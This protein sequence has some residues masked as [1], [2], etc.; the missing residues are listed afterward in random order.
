VID[1]SLVTTLLVLCLLVWLP[2]LLIQ[3]EQRG[4]LVFRIWLLTAP[5][6]TNI[7]AYPTL[8]PFFGAPR[9]ARGIQVA[10]SVDL[11][12]HGTIHLVEIFEPSRLL[13]HAFI[14]VFL[15]R[16]AVNRRVSVHWDRTE[17][18]MGVFSA[19]S[20]V[21]VLLKSEW[22][23]YGLRVTSDAFVVPFMGYFLARRFVTSEEN[24]R[25][26][27]RVIG[28][29]GFYLI[30]IALIEQITREQTGNFYRL[31]GP[32]ANRDLLYIVI[33]VSFFSTLLGS[34]G[35]K[36]HPNQSRALAPGVRMFVLAL[37]P[38]IIFLSWTR[39][40]WLGFISATGI[41]LVLGHRFITPG[42]KIGGIGIIL[43]LLPVVLL[44]GTESSSVDTLEERA[45]YTDTGY[46]RLAAWQV[47]IQEGMTNPLFGIG[48]NNLRNVLTTSRI[49]M[50][51]VR[52]LTV[53]HNCFLG[54]FVEL[55]AVGL[56]LY[57]LIV[58]CIIHTGLIICR[59]G[60][61]YRDRWRGI[62]VV[63]ILAAYLIPAFFSTILYYPGVSHIYVFAYAGAIVGLYRA[64]HSAEDIKRALPSYRTRVW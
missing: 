1:I 19:F 15:L 13:F 63:A 46:A 58:S 30:V 59:L 37:A 62:A 17:T 48:L 2:L 8:N 50:E 64:R 22:P 14:I 3:I 41:V 5:I 31:R 47:A 45:L 28:H 52:S 42:L 7:V 39:G 20:F 56:L 21:N 32:F 55:G 51:G 23:L 36:E 38:L 29:V 6:A 33:M 25:K 10:D 12:R 57:L 60:P 4:F 34:V 27:I 24:F 44:F 49:T 16:F 53:H 40:N 9:L 11:F 18:W 26:L 43:V 61:G 35:D 54:F